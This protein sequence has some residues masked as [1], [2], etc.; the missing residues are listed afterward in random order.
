MK[1]AQD[2]TPYTSGLN[3]CVHIHKRHVLTDEFLTL[4]EI[5]IVSGEQFFITNALKFS[6]TDDK[7]HVP[8]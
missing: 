7:L 4:W 8:S 1:G 5:A 3:I 2:S 6:L